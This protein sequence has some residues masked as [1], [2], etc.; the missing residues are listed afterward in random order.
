M[1]IERIKQ[2]A[3]LE[4]IT[5]AHIEREIGASQSTLSKAYK[6]KRDIQAKWLTSII[7]AYPE[8]SAHWLLTG[9]APIYRDELLQGLST[10]RTSSDNNVIIDSK[11]VAIY[12]RDLKVD[13]VVQTVFERLVEAKDMQ[14]QYLTKTLEKTQE[15]L[16]TLL[17]TK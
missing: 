17:G 8:Y 13:G 6:D 2:I 12:A 1:I 15:M 3:D 4:G 9:E 16:Q 11:D 10:N 14:I 5:L 7:K